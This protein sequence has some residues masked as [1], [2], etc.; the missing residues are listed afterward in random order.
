MAQNYL[1]QVRET[2]AKE[3]AMKDPNNVA[4]WK[5]QIE[6]LRD[7][8]TPATTARHLYVDRDNGFCPYLRFVKFDA[9]DK[10]D[11]PNGIAENSV[12]I[13]FEIDLFN[14]KVNVFN[15]GCIW[16]SPK[17]KTLPQYKYLCMKSM[18]DVLVDKGGKK[19]RKQGFKDMADLFKRMETY[20]KNVM[21]AVT[22]YTGGYPYKNGIEQPTEDVKAA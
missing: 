7:I 11:Y 14:K 10:N 3:N 22:E 17:D 19:F 16:L 21:Q 9:L 5:K 6:M 13:T 1:K 15:T 12:F 18:T 8:A 20:Y 4:E 2:M